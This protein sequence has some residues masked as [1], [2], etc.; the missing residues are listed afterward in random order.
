MSEGR[1]SRPYHI[2]LDEMNLA[3]IEYYFAKF[4]SAMEVRARQE[5]AAIDLGAQKQIY[6]YRN[7]FFIGTINVD[8]TTQG[9]SDKVFDRVQLIEL[10]KP[11]EELPVS[12]KRLAGNA[13]IVAEWPLSGPG[14]YQLQL[15]FAD[16]PVAVESAFV[17]IQPGKI[18]TEAYVQLLED[19]ETSLPASI[20]LALQ[21]NGAFANLS[22]FSPRESTLA[23]ELTCLERAIYGTAG[24]IGLVEALRAIS[25]QPYTVLNT[26]ELWVQSRYARR[27]HASRLVQAMANPNNLDKNGFPTRLLDTRVEHNV[28]VY[29]NRLLKVFWQQVHLRLRQL[30]SAL[31]RLEQRSNT[32]D[33][34]KRAQDLST[35]LYNARHEAAF[36]N[37]V[38]S[39][40]H[41]PTRV[42]MVLSQNPLY[43][44]ILEGYREFHRSMVVYL[45]EPLLEAPLENLP[46]LYQIWGTV[47]VLHVLLEEAGKRGYKV[48]KH[49]LVTKDDYGIYLRLLPDN[50]NLVVLEHPA[51]HTVIRFISERIYRRAAGQ[52]VHSISF[53]QRPDVAVEIFAPGKPLHILLFDPKYK[54]A[55]QSEDGRAIPK[56]EDIDK[57]HAYRDAIRDQEQKQ[58]IHYAAILYPGLYQHYY[59]GLEALQAYPGSQ[60][61]LQEHLQ[62][63]FRVA[64]QM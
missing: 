24:R 62:D 3:R 7:L 31:K 10:P 34:L 23:T 27:P 29:E 57:M 30:Q 25:S 9:F 17:T 35:A 61:S 64:L 48:G 8:E 28:D 59:D 36:L 14:H 43:R 19:L 49:E 39:P 15:Y 1:R 42:T 22:F 45:K 33:L 32:L 5:V 41:L 52:D 54:L 12:L 6:L 46:F 58:V 44:A 11:H 2:V 55:G 26:H 21:R 20:V 63:I 16:K 56:K 40:I 38:A 47:Q 18:S 50:K 51:D 53:E 13:R 37:E 4:L 60:V